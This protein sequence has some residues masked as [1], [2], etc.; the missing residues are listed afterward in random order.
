M[1]YIKRILESTISD[2]SRPNKVIVILGARRVGKTVMLKQL[3]ERTQKR[4]LYLNCE[5]L[6]VKELL[7]ERSI[8]NYRRQF[9]G[10]ERLFLD[11]AQTIAEIGLIIKLIVDEIDGIEVIATGSSAFDLLNRFGDPLTGRSFTYHLFPLSQGEFSGYETPLETKQNLHARLL[12]GSYPEVISYQGIDQK[13]EYLQNL[14]NTYLL[15]DIMAI[16]GLRGASKMIDLLQLIAFQVGN[17]VSPFELSKS[18]GISK[19]TIDK[20]LDLLSKVFIIFRLSG[21]SKNLRKEISKGQ[22]WYFFDNG[23]RNAII[24]EFKPINLRN[25]IGSLWE[26][27]II[28]ERYKRNHYSREFSKMHFWRTYDQQEIDLIEVNEGQISAF[29]IKWNPRSSTPSPKAWSL[30]YPESKFNVITPNN[31]LDFII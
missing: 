2:I 26:N 6:Y 11:E 16:D 14:V 28:S 25:D 19:N 30:N 22:K 20:Y 17:E 12:F 8:A 29:E 31:Y 13:R 21:F 24:S 1:D 15:K 4:S 5:D 27:Y 9:S 3:M 23:V 18:L 10:V 7:K